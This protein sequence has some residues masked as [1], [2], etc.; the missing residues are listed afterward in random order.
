M[1]LSDVETTHRRPNQPVGA[2]GEGG[3]EFALVR[4]QLVH[5]LDLVEVERKLARDA[6]VDASLQIGG[7]VL[8][9]DVLATGVFLADPRDTRVD[10]L[11]A[12]DVLDGSLPEEEV[13]VLTDVE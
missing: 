5:I 2:G 4:R 13:H 3:V 7:P 12:V 11:S 6:A 8:V 1:H 10:G 9:E